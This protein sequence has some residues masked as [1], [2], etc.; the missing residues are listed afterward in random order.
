M[1]GRVGPAAPEITQHIAIEQCM[2]LTN[3]IH[4]LHW[5]N[6]SS[7]GSLVRNC[8]LYGNHAYQPQPLAAAAVNSIFK[9]PAKGGA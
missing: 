2:L 9:P 5:F 3:G 1:R 6:S 7:Y 8:T 4:G